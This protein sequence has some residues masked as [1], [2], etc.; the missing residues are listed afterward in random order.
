MGVDRVGLALPAAGPA[1][2]LLTLDDDQAGG[3]DCASQP[4]TKA[5][6]ALDRDDHPRPRRKRRRRGQGIA[7]F[8]LSGGPCIASGSQIGSLGPDRRPTHYERV[9]RLR[10]ATDGRRIALDSALLCWGWR[11][12]VMDGRGHSRGTR[13][14][15]E[16]IP[17]LRLGGPVTRDQF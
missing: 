9:Q 17:R 4:D 1:V 11:R 13:V 12:L 7:E 6:R 5:A 16:L 14:P 15:P 2:G 3:N 8:L 10:V